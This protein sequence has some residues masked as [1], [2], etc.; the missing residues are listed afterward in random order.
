MCPLRQLQANG[1]SANTLCFRAVKVPNRVT[2]S[3]KAMQSSAT[4]R[5]YEVALPEFRDR[6]ELSIGF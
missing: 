6:A 2:L 3:G 5:D 4:G 1:E